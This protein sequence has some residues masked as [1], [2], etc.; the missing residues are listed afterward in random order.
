MPGFTPTTQFKLR[1]YVVDS[2]PGSIVEAAVDSIQ[3]IKLECEASCQ[4]DLEDPKSDDAIQFS[5][6]KN[7]NITNDVTKTLASN[8]FRFPKKQGL[9]SNTDD[10]DD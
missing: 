7:V 3:L 2:E 1:F 6:T 10:D 4:A 9:P 5:S 8:T